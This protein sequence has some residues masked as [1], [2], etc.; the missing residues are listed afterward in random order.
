MIDL[1]NPETDVI[2]LYNNFKDYMSTI[3]YARHRDIL[4]FYQYE[5]FD[6]MHSK[7]LYGKWDENS[8]I[9][10]RNLCKRIEKQLIIICEELSLIEYIGDDNYIFINE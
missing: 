5:I 6:W 7:S 10:Y 2:E 1:S 4:H 8:W 3:Y 9:E